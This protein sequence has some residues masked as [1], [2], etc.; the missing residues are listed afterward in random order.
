MLKRLLLATA[1]V[2]PVSLARADTITIGYSDLST[3]GGAI[4]TLGTVSNFDPFLM[5][6]FFLGSGFGFGSI[7][8]LLIPQGPGQAPAFEFAFHNGFVPPEGG[9]IRLYATWQGANVPGNPVTFPTSF[10][11][12][13]MPGG[14]NGL[15]VQSQIFVCS[16]GKVYC[17]GNYLAPGGQQIGAQYIVDQFDNTNLTLSHSVPSHPFA[18]TEERQISCTKYPIQQ[19]SLL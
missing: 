8:A 19:T 16:N 12:D 2:A 17:D 9:T 3:D 4:T 18:I 7:T 5:Q 1:L 10:G 14:S 6:Y 11:V 15:F 13:E